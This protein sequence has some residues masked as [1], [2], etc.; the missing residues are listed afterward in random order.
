M[1]GPQAI[2]RILEIGRKNW[3]WGVGLAIVSLLWNLAAG[4]H[5]LSGDPNCDG[6]AYHLVTPKVWLQEGRSV[7]ILHQAWTSF[8]SL[9]ETLFGV[10]MALSSIRIV[11]LIG[12]VFYGLFL[13]QIHGLFRRFGASVQVSDWALLVVAASPIFSGQILEGYV[14]LPMACLAL[15]GLRIMAVEGVDERNKV[16]LLGS[17]CGML[18][19][20]KYHGIFATVGFA[21][22]LLAGEK[23]IY[24]VIKK[25][26]VMGAL[27]A[28][29]AGFWYMRNW[30]T[31]GSPIY[32]PTMGLDKVFETP[33]FPQ[34]SIELV[35]RHFD[36]R[37]FGYGT[38][39]HHLLSLPY[40]FTFFPGRFEAAGGI[41]L[42]PLCFLPFAVV[43]LGRSALGQSSLIWCG[44][45]TLTWFYTAQ[46]GRYA[47]PVISVV[48]IFMAV[49]WEHIRATI[50]ES[51]LLSLLLIGLVIPSVLTGCYQQWHTRR[52]QISS[53]N[54][55]D[56]NE[57]WKKNIPHLDAI[58][59]I[60][61]LN[62]IG[63]ILVLNRWFPNLYIRHPVVKARGGF[64]EKPYQGVANEEELLARLNDYSITHIL[65]TKEGK[66]NF[67]I[68]P[69]NTL[70][71]TLLYEDSGAR[72]YRVKSLN[73]HKRSIQSCLWNP[74]P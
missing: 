27:C 35:K 40:L 50:R 37:C 34:E 47:L 67:I 51:R 39:I 12:V 49:G 69:V 57:A 74:D 71:W 38:Q 73:H 65:D 36:E 44:W 72:V 33:Y 3:G 6:I 63:Q 17:V 58:R 26:I 45:M 8:P 61:K 32:P 60:N 18:M 7:V 53:I 68:P 24:S 1:G 46:N 54:N 15:A 14:D 9:I 25:W 16:V 41:G 20:T 56:S 21:L 23:T 64:G 10:G 43:V 55:E 52:G 19:A 70:E 62:D 31:V 13:L 59:A 42:A 48:M 5:Y 29:I 30:V 28:V 66:Q 2:F 11:G 22:A 4:L